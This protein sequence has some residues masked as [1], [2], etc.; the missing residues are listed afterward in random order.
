MVKDITKLNFKQMKKMGFENILFDK[1][2]TVT[3]P[4][5][6]NFFNKDI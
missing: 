2:N 5:G 1:D 4:G 6:L 3:V